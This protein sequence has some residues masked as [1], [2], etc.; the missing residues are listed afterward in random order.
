M[1]PV[2]QYR[3]EPRQFNYDR[4]QHVQT[5]AFNAELLSLI[6]GVEVNASHRQA[7]RNTDTEHPHSLPNIG[8]SPDTLSLPNP[9]SWL[10]RQID[11]VAHNWGHSLTR[12]WIQMY[13]RTPEENVDET[14]SAEYVFRCLRAGQDPVPAFAGTWFNEKFGA[15]YGSV[16]RW[17]DRVGN[18]P[19]PSLDIQE[20]D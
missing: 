3:N 4:W 9:L 16:T 8:L 15:D 11:E 7:E 18:G 10:E 19:I 13:C 14:T 2:T 6:Q 5:L 17:L 1:V 12:V 20:K